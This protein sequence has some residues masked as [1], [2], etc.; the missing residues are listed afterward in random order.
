VRA[1]PAW[2]IPPHAPP[3]YRQAMLAYLNRL[4]AKIFAGNPAAVGAFPW[5]ASLGIARTPNSGQR[6]DPYYAH[7]CGGVIFSAA[8]IITAAHCTDGLA[9]SDIDVTAG[10]NTL[11][12]SAPYSPVRMIYVYVHYQSRNEHDNDIALLALSRP[13]PLGRNLA[14]I[15][16]LTPQTEAATLH[17]GAALIITGWG[18]TFENGKQVRE[19]LY[20]R[21]NL[22]VGAECDGPLAYGNQVTD[23]MLC[24]ANGLLHTNTCNGDSGGPLSL[25]NAR[26][27]LAGITSWGAGECD[28]PGLPGVYTRVSLFNAVIANCAIH[29]D[30]SAWKTRTQES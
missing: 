20:G 24:A 8:W 22:V 26:P 3:E 17:P 7:Y 15:D 9:P 11:T 23:S 29:H 25:D 16:L 13:L 28:I 18:G 6:P 4:Q 5:Q 10:S 1:A 2:I 19:L 14:P 12:T 30:C 21:V 27:L